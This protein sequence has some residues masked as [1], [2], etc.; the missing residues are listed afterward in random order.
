[1]D[2]KPLTEFRTEIELG[3]SIY[4]TPEGFW[5][6]YRDP[7]HGKYLWYPEVEI[8]SG[9]SGHWDTWEEMLSVLRTICRRAHMDNLRCLPG[10]LVH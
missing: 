4:Q 6:V 10:P 1:M 7:S 5:H 8:T 9:E 2:S 3:L